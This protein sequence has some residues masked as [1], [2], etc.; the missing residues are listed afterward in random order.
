MMLCAKWVCAGT[1]VDHE[2]V[3]ESTISRHEEEILGMELDYGLGVPC[4]A[5]WSLLWFSSPTR[6]NEIL[7]MIWTSKSITKLSTLLLRTLFCDHLEG[8]T[9]THRGR[10]CWHQWQRSYTEHIRSGK[11]TKRWK[12]GWMDGKRESWTLI[13][14]WWWWRRWEVRWW[15]RWEWGWMI[16]YHRKTRPLPTQEQCTGYLLSSSCSSHKRKRLS[17]AKKY[18]GGPEEGHDREKSK[19][20]KP[21]LVWDHENP[22]GSSP[23]GAAGDTA[24]MT[25]GSTQNQKVSGK[26]SQQNWRGW[27]SR[28]RKEK[29]LAQEWQV[30]FEERSRT[31]HNSR[32]CGHRRKTRRE[33]SMQA[34]RPACRISEKEIS[35]IWSKGASLKRCTRNL[36]AAQNKSYEAEQ[37]LCSALWEYVEA[38]DKE[39]GRPKIIMTKLWQLIQSR[40]NKNLNLEKDLEEIVSKMKQTGWRRFWAQDE[41]VRKE[42][43]TWRWWAGARSWTSSLHTFFVV[44]ALKSSLLCLLTTHDAAGSGQIGGA[45]M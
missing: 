37:K 41:D 30:E 40:D 35:R 5:Q 7:D 45:E 36:D 9:H 13:L 2:W 11:W 20:D 14:W 34:Q 10:A 17:G 29:H 16:S 26:K 39:R 38:F 15:R 1:F 12:D 32:K 21:R 43:L 27:G 24:P 4:V 8:N 33:R 19:V 42:T 22:G 3:S 25:R 31:L 23:Q 44:S 18:N 28:E 6:L